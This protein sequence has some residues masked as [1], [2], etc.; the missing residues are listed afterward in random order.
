M[1]KTYDD[2]NLPK[3]R[4]GFGGRTEYLSTNGSVPVWRTENGNRVEEYYKSKSVSVPFSEDEDK[5]SN[6]RSKSDTEP[7]LHRKH[8]YHRWEYKDKKYREFKKSSSGLKELQYHSGCFFPHD[9]TLS[10]DSR[11]VWQEMEYLIKSADENGAPIDLF[12][13]DQSYTPELMRKRKINTNYY[14]Q[15]PYISKKAPRIYVDS[16][17]YEENNLIILYA[18]KDQK[19]WDLTFTYFFDLATGE[20]Y[21]IK[22]ESVPKDVLLRIADDAKSIIAMSDKGDE[23]FPWEKCTLEEDII[24]E[25]TGSEN[26]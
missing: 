23:T 4:T 10:E 22:N 9:E 3:T 8:N 16:K 5:P 13:K 17:V 6:S 18:S 25:N 19:L 7:V 26:Q 14:L 2:G 1:S 15:T 21:R 11:Y 20:T 24:K 12:T